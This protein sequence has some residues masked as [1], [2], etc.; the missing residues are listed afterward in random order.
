MLVSDVYMYIIKYLSCTARTY[1]EKSWCKRMA[2]MRYP[3]E[4]TG[5]NK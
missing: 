5:H 4:F 1:G 3:I 2:I